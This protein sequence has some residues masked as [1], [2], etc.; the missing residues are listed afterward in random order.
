MILWGCLEG[1]DVWVWSS[2]AP[3]LGG[4]SCESWGSPQKQKNLPQ[5]K[6]CVAQS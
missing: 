5:S 2:A 1:M 3:S 4:G 6:A